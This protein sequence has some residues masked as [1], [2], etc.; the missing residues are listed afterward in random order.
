MTPTTRTPTTR[1]R[2]AA[3]PAGTRARADAPVDHR[4][5]DSALDRVLAGIDT[6]VQRQHRVTIPAGATATIPAASVTLVY[7]IE[8]AVSVDAIAHG[9]ARAESAAGAGSRFSAGDALM[10][11]GREPHTLRIP[12]HAFLLVSTL[13]FTEASSHLLPLL[14][15]ML[16]VRDLAGSEPAVAALASR[17]GPELGS[18]PDACAAE[19]GSSVVCRMM[20]NTVLVSVIRTWVLH[21]CAPDGWPSRTNDPFLDRVLE[22]IH[23]DP[24][25][26]WTIEDLARAGAM[27]RSVFAAR[28]RTATGTSPASY[29]AE[30][31]I[32]S[33]QDLLARGL[34]VSE[35]SRAIGYGSDEGFS[36]AFR[37]H[38][39]QSP[40]AWRGA[41]LRTAA[42]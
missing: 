24:A 27:S 10:F 35:V 11:T 15:D 18:G 34:G 8:G 40:S 33:A 5:P 2:A 39:G 41:A 42:A 28:F 25:R 14:P 23:A 6:R 16:S 17:L 30:V 36:R 26:A 37:R 4:G 32:R 3:A 29:L 7:L 22:A 1:T 19:P 12:D 20:A 13:A 9:S 31:R 38:V 21:G